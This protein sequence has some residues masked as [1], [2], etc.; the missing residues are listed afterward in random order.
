MLM[1][2]QRY[3]ETKNWRDQK[4]DDAQRTGTKMRLID[5]VLC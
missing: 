2:G 3:A 5:E 1:A 4:Q